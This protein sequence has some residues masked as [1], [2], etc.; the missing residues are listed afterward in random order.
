MQLK[1]LKKLNKE[2]IYIIFLKYLSDNLSPTF[3][4]A[5]ILYHVI[6]WYF[7]I[8]REVTNSVNH[9][10]VFRVFLTTGYQPTRNKLPDIITEGVLAAL[11]GQ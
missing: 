8:S 7:V 3:F 4:L 11:Y 5:L 10:P 2:N 1:S 6:Q 9:Q